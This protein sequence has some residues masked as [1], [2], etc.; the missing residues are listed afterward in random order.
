[1]PSADDSAKRARHAVEQPAREM[2]PPDRTSIAVGVDVEH[3]AVPREAF[4]LDF[5]RLRVEMPVATCG[6]R[7][8]DRNDA[9]CQA[10]ARST[11]RRGQH[12][13]PHIVIDFDFAVACGPARLTGVASVPVI[14]N[15]VS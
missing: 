10:G 9:L 5:E 14:S 3:L 1:M 2:A 8:A 4:R 12:Q 7:V 15:W 13:V 11:R 6:Y